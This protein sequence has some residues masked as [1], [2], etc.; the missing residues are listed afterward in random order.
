MEKSQSTSLSAFTKAQ[1]RVSIT[2]AGLDLQE[3]FK[4]RQKAQLTQK[5]IFTQLFKVFTTI[6]NTN[7]STGMGL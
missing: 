4:S 6:G 5:E 3:I 1:Q 7:L 2:T